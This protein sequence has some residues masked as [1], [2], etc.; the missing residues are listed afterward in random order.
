[1]KKYWLDC[2]SPAGT[3]FALYRKDGEEDTCILKF[4]YEDIDGLKEC[5]DAGLIGE[6]YE[7]LDKYIEEKLGFLPDYVIG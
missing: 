1:M 6:G 3:Q 4:G 7:L 5:E 2:D